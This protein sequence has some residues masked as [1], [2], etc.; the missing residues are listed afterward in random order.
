MAYASSTSV[1]VSK[2]KVEIEN[3]LR[4]HGATGFGFFE[5]R[6]RGMVVFEMHH[7]RIRFVIPIPDKMET[8][9]IRTSHGRTR[10]VESCLAAWEQ[11]CR[12]RWR[13]LLLCI[14]AKLESVE[15]GIESFEDSFLS[16]IQMPDGQTVG[17]LVR[18]RIEHA[19]THQE[20][21]P[22]LPAPKA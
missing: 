19:Y 2:T 20:M 22:L 17:E 21:T 18:P 15:A 7:R 6:A 13:A 1:S 12:S 4:K 14:K 11:A 10:S 9:F 5:E 16:H 8:R 3:L